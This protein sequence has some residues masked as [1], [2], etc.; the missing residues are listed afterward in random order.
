MNKWAHLCGHSSSILAHLC[1]H[2][3]SILTCKNTFYIVASANC[4]EQ[5]INISTNMILLKKGVF[6]EITLLLMRK[7]Y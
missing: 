4:G 2:R 1:G 5:K 3:S 6:I 7:A